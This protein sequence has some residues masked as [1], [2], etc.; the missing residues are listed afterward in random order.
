PAIAVLVLAS[1]LALFAAQVTRQSFDLEYGRGFIWL[2]GLQFLAALG[3]LVSAR[4]PGAARSL[5]GAILATPL[6]HLVLG[7]RALSW[8]LHP[9]GW[10]GVFDRRLSSSLRWSL[11]GRTLI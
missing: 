5:A 6:T 10:K 9:L 3:L 7:G 1:F 2:V 8:L 4:I 11:A